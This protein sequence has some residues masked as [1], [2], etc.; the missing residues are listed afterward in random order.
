LPDLKEEKRV[1]VV[2]VLSLV[3][4]TKEEEKFDNGTV[5]EKLVFLVPNSAPINYQNFSKLFEE[6]RKPDPLYF[7]H[8]KSK[9]SNLYEKMVASFFIRRV[10]KKEKE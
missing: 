8:G 9:K 2:K 4:K 6:G 5:S 1:G 3:S 10:L 7:P